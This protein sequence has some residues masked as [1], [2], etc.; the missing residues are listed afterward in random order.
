MWP[1]SSCE[2]DVAEDPFS[3]DQVDHRLWIK[4]I[5]ISSGPFLVIA[6]EATK[7]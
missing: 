2:A 6:L 1:T 7:W 5:L 4:I 3:L